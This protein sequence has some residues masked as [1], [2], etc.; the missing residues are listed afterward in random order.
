MAEHPNVET[1]RRGHE[2]FWIRHAWA[3]NENQAG[4]DALVG[5]S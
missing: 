3:H 1:V 5:G 2:A 4:L